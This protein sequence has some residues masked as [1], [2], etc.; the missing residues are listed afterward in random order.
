MGKHLLDQTVSELQCVLFCP[1]LSLLLIAPELINLY[2]GICFK[3]IKED[4]H[5][6]DQK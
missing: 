6:L 4:K 3:K 5:L 2:I 1:K